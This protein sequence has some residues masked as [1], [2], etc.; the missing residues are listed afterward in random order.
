MNVTRQWVTSLRE[1]GHDAVHWSRI[2]ADNADDL[3]IM[4]WARD[5]AHINFTEDLDFGTELSRSGVVRPSVVLL[6]TPLNLPRYVGSKVLDAIAAAEG[7]LDNG[8]LLVVSSKRNRVRSLP[9]SRSR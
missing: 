6:R 7:A 4:R 8:A 1:L 9:L 5:N 2:G 3:D